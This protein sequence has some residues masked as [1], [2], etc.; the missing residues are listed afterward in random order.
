MADDGASPASPAHHQEERPSR[1]RLS[2]DVHTRASAAELGGGSQHSQ[3]TNSVENLVPKRT[4][5]PPAPGLSDDHNLE[6]IDSATG[7]VIVAEPVNTVD[8]SIDGILKPQTEIDLHAQRMKKT[9]KPWRDAFTKTTAVK[10][11]MLSFFYFA[12]G[13]PFGFYSNTYLLVLRTNGVSRTV[14]SLTQFLIIPWVLK[15]LWAPLIDAFPSPEKFHWIRRRYAWLVPQGVIV[16]L[17]LFIS[18]GISGHSETMSRTVM[19]ELAASIFFQNLFVASM[20]IAVDGLAVDSLTQDE[21]GFG[22]SMQVVAYK[23]GILVGGALLAYCLFPKWDEML[24]VNSILFVFS[25]VMGIFFA[26]NQ[27]KN[28]MPQRVRT[29]SEVEFPKIGELSQTQVVWKQLIKVVFSKEQRWVLLAILWY[30]SGEVIGDRMFKLFLV[31]YGYSIPDISLYIG[32]FA[33]AFSIAGSLLGAP[34]SR[35]LNPPFALLVLAVLT[36]I[37]QFFRY[38]L[39]AIPAWH[40]S[41]GAIVFV[42]IA[43]NLVSGCLTTVMFSFMMSQVDHG[44]GASHYAAFAVLEVIGKGVPDLL[45]GYLTD[46]FGYGLIFFVTILLESVFIFIAAALLMTLKRNRK[47]Q[48]S[49]V[50]RPVDRRFLREVPDPM[51]ED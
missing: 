15:P 12:Q 38:L 30:K 22:N 41:L 32:F 25:I 43:G 45:S 6:R 2:T 13:L 21:L 42:E 10:L 11:V 20:D 48:W 16:A 7:G 36:T 31:D 35:V 29:G 33:D 49:Q 50:W 8:K 34:F 44:I 40:S 26:E 51:E 23:F 27:L 18:A 24:C 14:I 39:V 19:N 1:D 4:P 17:I 5:G 46:R 9:Q 28:M 47:V 3:N 37:M